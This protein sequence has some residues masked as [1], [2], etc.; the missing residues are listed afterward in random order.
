MLELKT[1][2]G[3]VAVISFTVAAN[4]MLKLGASAPFSQRVFLGGFGWKSAAGLGLFGCGGIL[5]A[6]L[7][8]QVPLNL[9]QAFA[10]LQFVGVA[11]AASFV[12]G[13]SISVLRW[14]GIAF[15]CCSVS[16]AGLSAYG[17]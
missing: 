14:V 8:R 9:A 1:F 7:L 15:I 2:I 10:A 13:Q 5:Y 4:M 16:L 11:V 12:F 6:L 3:F 17:W